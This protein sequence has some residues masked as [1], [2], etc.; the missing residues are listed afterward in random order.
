MNQLAHQDLLR[1]LAGRV[2]FAL[3]WVIAFSPLSSA[4]AEKAASNSL[5]A[6]AGAVAKRGKVI[7]FDDEV[8]EGLNKRPLDSLSQISERDRRRRSHL[9]RKRSGFSSETRETLEALR[10]QQ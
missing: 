7:D 3:L 8:V 1:K 4:A 9:Y 5:R 10:Y 6:D 2:G